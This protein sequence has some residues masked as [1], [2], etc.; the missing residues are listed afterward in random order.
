MYGLLCEYRSY[1]KQAVRE[2]AT[3]RRSPVQVVTGRWHI[4]CWR[5]NK[6]RG[7]FNSQLKRP[8]DLDAF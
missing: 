6:L 1:L 8:G 4:N 5:R 7:D 2:A 3:I